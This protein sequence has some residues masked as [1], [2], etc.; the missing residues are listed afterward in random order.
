LRVQ[1]PHQ[2]HHH[3]GNRSFQCPRPFRGALPGAG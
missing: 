3:R 2:N 1:H